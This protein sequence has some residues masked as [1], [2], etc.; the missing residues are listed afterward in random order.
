MS[1]R[2]RDYHRDDGQM[3]RT[4]PS[5]G[6]ALPHV[7]RLSLILIGVCLAVFLAQA[8]T[9]RTAERSPLVNFGE[10]TYFQGT[11][12]FQPWRFL[13]YQYLH[14]SG[15]HIFWNCLG[16]FFF[17][18]PLE[19]LWGWKKTLGFYTL[20][21]VAA[22]LLYGVI[23]A[24]AHLGAG[25]LIGASGSI[26]A[27]MAG[28][29]LLFPGMQIILVFFPVP[30][31]VAAGLFFV[32]FLL[33]IVGDKDLSNAA[34]LGGL[35]FGFFAPM[36]RPWFH[37]LN[38]KIQA[39]RVMQQVREEAEEERIVDRILEKVRDHGMQSLNNSEKRAL[40]RATERQ[41]R[42]DQLRMR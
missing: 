42:R 1:W 12:W 6:F 31:R 41:R 35:A 15:S 32:F 28:C 38:A 3:D 34:H 14:G 4:M 24:A 36:T 18:P 26:F 17:V 16:I 9:G 19:R 21:G 25:G 30:I 27:C 11:A 37:R 20:G 5:V 29:A 8:G 23:N 33:T 13:T 2:D 7:S 39:Q 10:L 40:Q 22:G